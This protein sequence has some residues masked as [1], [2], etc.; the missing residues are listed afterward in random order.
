MKENIYLLCGDED[1]LIDQRISQLIKNQGFAPEN[2]EKIEG[3][4]ANLFSLIENISFAGLFNAQRFILVEAKALFETPAKN[5]KT[6]QLDVFIGALNNLDSSIVLVFKFRGWPDK[7]KEF[8][9]KLKKIAQV[10]E[11]AALNEWAK[12]K[13]I[14]FVIN[15][16]RQKGKEISPAS[17]SFMIDLMGASFYNLASEIDKLNA[18]IGERN[19]IETADIKLQ[20]AESDINVFLLSHQIGQKKKSAAFAILNKLMHNNPEP[21]AILG[22]MASQIRMLLQIK[23]LSQN[24]PSAYSLAQILKSNHFYVQKSLEQSRN[25]NQA[26]LMHGLKRIKQAGLNI[27]SGNDAKTELSLT[28]KEILK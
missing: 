26:S 11:F 4:F 28:L 12:D 13:A 7:R 16:A 24:N 19:K 10:E 14:D 1:Y 27:K 2:V 17:A 20:T 5:K 9:L 23:I 22:L 21:F 8:Y 6:E 3:S 25:F 15:Y 18:Y